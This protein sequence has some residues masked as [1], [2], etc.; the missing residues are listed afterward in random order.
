M[1]K[2]TF[3]TSKHQAEQLVLR[4]NAGQERDLSGRAILISIGSPDDNTLKLLPGTLATSTLIKHVGAPYEP[5]K[6]DSPHW[7]EVVKLEFND[8]DPSHCSEEW[9]LQWKLFDDEMANQVIDAFERQ[10][11]KIDIVVAHCEAGVSRS[12][13]IC[14]FAAVYFNMHIPALDTYMLHNKHVFSTLLRVWRQRTYTTQSW[15]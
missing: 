7:L 2:T 1:P 8:I 6:V 15:I 4:M 12:A 14:K 3:F 10:A 5:P 13:A 11:G 9:V